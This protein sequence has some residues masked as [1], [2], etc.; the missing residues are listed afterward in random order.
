MR[1]SH[2][3]HPI[4]ARVTRT[5]TLTR[6]APHRPAFRPRLEGLEDRTTP[7]GGVLDPTFGS[8][9]T[10]LNNPG[11]SQQAL[12]DV[13]VLPDGKLLTAGYFAWPCS[14]Q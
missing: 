4:A 5:R 3:L 1:I 9:G 13:V 10:V 6:R 12:T 11:S 14:R 7:S 8:G 2:W